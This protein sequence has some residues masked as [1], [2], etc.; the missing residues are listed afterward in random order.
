MS[1]ETTQ[2][3]IPQLHPDLKQEISHAIE[4]Y[5][6]RLGD[7]HVTSP[8][9]D[10]TSPS[11]NLL[12]EIRC[13]QK[14]HPDQYDELCL[15]ILN[16]TVTAILSGIGQLPAPETV[17]E[18]LES[19]DPIASAYDMHLEQMGERALSVSRGSEFLTPQ[20]IAE[21]V[22]SKEGFGKVFRADHL[23]ATMICIFQ[24]R[25]NPNPGTND[26][27]LC[28]PAK[29]G[30]RP[31]VENGREALEKLPPGQEI[32]EMRIVQTGRGTGEIFPMRRTVADCLKGA[33][34][35]GDWF[36]QQK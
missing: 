31:V 32:I 27:F 1:P 5:L 23:Y 7:A 8:N 4:E 12:N 22:R 26:F 21:S 28:H 19:E 33:F 3:S 30:Q 9:G 11:A 24:E 18:L 34:T 14:D 35:L 2:E 17:K 20:Q 10:N 25:Q 16:V 6:T 15:R 36:N 13:L 29:N